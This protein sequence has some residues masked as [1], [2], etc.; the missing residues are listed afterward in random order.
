MV[1]VCV[2]VRVAGPVVVSAEVVVSIAATN[3][4]NKISFF[5]QME[6]N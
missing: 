6:S 3:F 2:V 5:N 1:C 4:Q